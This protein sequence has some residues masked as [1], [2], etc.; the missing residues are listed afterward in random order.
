MLKSSDRRPRPE[1]DMQKA[2]IEALRSSV[3]LTSGGKPDEAIDLLEAA[4]NQLVVA[5]ASQDVLFLSLYASILCEGLH[6]EGRARRILRRALQHAATDTRTL[7]SLARLY[8][9]VG[10]FRVARA[11][12]NRRRETDAEKNN[13]GLQ[14][15]IEAMLKQ[16]AE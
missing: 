3:R 14:E 9:K 13:V 16:L 15:V 6:D 1:I 2:T 7:L 12:L 5:N 10:K 11:L 4:F 8:Q